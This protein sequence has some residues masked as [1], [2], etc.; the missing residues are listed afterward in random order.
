MADAMATAS[1]NSAALGWIALIEQDEIDKVWASMTNDFRLVV[2]QNWIWN[3][4]EVMAEPTVTGSRD[5]LAAELSAP[6][7]SHPLWTRGLA[8]VAE[9]GLRGVTTDVLAGREYGAGVRPRPAGVDLELVRVL[10]LNELAVDEDG[11]HIF[12]PGQLVECVS[13]LMRRVDDG[14][15]VAGAGGWLP[16]PG[17]PPEFEMIVELSD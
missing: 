1:A 13:L 10:P 9:R 14:W 7:R 17:W 6:E 12:A 8:G 5:E 3:N 4:P 15:R 2:V 16:R 11:F